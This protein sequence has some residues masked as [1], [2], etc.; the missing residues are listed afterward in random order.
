MDDIRKLL[1]KI[2]EKQ[3]K[4][5]EQL[6]ALGEAMNN[7]KETTDRHTNEMKDTNE[8]LFEY[9]KQLEIHILGVQELQKAN[10]LYQ[11]DL[12]LKEIEMLNR[13]AIA[14]KPMIW[15]QNFAKAVLWVGGFIGAIMA[16]IEA[17]KFVAKH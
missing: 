15:L 12:K 14:E 17:I 9:N 4:Q 11:S 16:I 7:Q 2:D 13:M 6:A 1:N 5:S 3:D 10:E 8:K